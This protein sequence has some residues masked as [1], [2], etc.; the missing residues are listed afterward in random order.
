MK[1]FF[2]QLWRLFF[3]KDRSVN[4]AKGLVI[5]KF[6]N[7]ERKIN[8]LT[9]KFD[10]W[11][12]NRKRELRIKFNS[13]VDAFKFFEAF[14]LAEREQK[15]RKYFMVFASGFGLIIQIEDVCWIT[16]CHE[17]NEPKIIE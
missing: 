5:V 2:K 17:G 16:V 6:K 13:L 12:P 1:E 9:G 14:K 7:R 8:P 4:I 15:D 10:R 11:K 3:S